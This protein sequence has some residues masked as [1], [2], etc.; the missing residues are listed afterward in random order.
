MHNLLI[1]F[2]HEGMVKSW[3]VVEDKNLDQELDRFDPDIGDSPLDL[4]SP[5]HAKARGFYDTSDLVLTSDLSGI[6]Y[7]ALAHFECSHRPQKKSFSFTPVSI[8][9]R[10]LMTSFLVVAPAFRNVKSSCWGFPEI[11]FVSVGTRTGTT[12]HPG[13][14]NKDISAH[15]KGRNKKSAGKSISPVFITTRSYVDVEWDTANQGAA[16]QKNPEVLGSVVV[17]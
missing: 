10:F 5:L 12:T 8:A 7:N 4:S 2:D 14:A 15:A 16:N 1:Q 3:V 17:R 6:P 9:A 13:A 11:V